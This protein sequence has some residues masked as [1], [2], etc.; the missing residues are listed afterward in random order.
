MQEVQLLSGTIHL[1][2]EQAERVEQATKHAFWPRLS[3]KQQMFCK[4]YIV[5][6][7]SIAAVKDAYVVTGKSAAAMAGVLLKEPKIRQVLN[8][9]GLASEGVPVSRKELVQLMSNRMRSEKVQTAVWVKLVQM[10]IDLNKWTPTKACAANKPKMEAEITD[11][12]NDTVLK[13][14]ASRRNNGKQSEEE[15]KEQG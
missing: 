8:L 4:A 10:F 12:I 15:S 9:T 3:Q 1:D 7:D 6:N 2:T 5:H 13:L 11:S 14:E